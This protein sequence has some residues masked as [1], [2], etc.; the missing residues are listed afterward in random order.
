[1]GSFLSGILGTNSQYQPSS[2]Q[3]GNPYGPQTLQ[4]LVNQ[5]TALNANQNALGQQ[6]QE[7]IAGRGPNPA[8]TQYL[9]NVQNNIAN[10]QGQIAS[11]RGLNPAVA[12]KLGANA[13]A[14]ANQQA[15]QQ[16]SLLQQQQQ[17]GATANYANLLGQ[18]QQGNLGY[19][20]LY[21][22]PNVAAMQTNAA[23]ANANQQQSAGLVGGLL[24]G[25]GSA[26]SGLLAHGGEVKNYEEGGFVDSDPTTPQNSALSS[27]GK[28]LSGKGD[29]SI[30]GMG[31]GQG[32][33]LSQG[34]G[35]LGAM[36]GS[37][38]SQVSK[39]ISGLLSGAAEGMAKGGKVHNFKPGGPVPGKAKVAGDSLKNDTVN[40][41]LS[42]GE[43]VLPRTVVNGPNAPDK[44]A[45]FVA[46]ILAKKGI[47]S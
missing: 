41:K 12:A 35:P 4:Y 11:Q 22:N 18:E 14:A 1:M 28:Y 16:S 33:Y 45:R 20:Q 7:Q 31:S 32:G 27:I 25:V 30:Q 42:P 46:A 36:G 47:R 26:L 40:A 24:G 29:Q 3:A 44:S 39:G 2:Y 15:A 17:L 43:I 21:V 37:G 5:Q 6:L 34:F 23:V 8:Q 19:Q 13:G 10:T 38:G 9:Q